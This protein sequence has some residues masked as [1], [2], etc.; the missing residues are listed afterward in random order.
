[1]VSVVVQQVK[2]A[3]ESERKAAMEK[4]EKQIVSKK[5]TG[6]LENTRI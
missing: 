2:E 5:I 4:Y 6:D 3:R 1:M